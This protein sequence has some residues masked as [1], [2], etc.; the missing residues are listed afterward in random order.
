MKIQTLFVL[1]ATASLFAQVPAT[2]TTTPAPAEIQAAISAATAP[3]QIRCR[4]SFDAVKTTYPR[5][6][7]ADRMFSLVDARVRN[8]EAT[9]KENRTG[10]LY[11]AEQRSCDLSVELFKTQLYKVALQRS[12]DSLN[13][14]NIAAQKELSL[15]KDSLIDL[16]SREALGAKSLNT[17]GSDERARLEQANKEKA[18]ELESSQKA[19]AHK[20]AMLAAQKAEAQKRLD[21]LNS[22]AMSVYRDARGTI[23]SMSDI[24]FE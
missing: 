13:K 12:I 2:V 18:R 20:D 16:W 11:E 21:A 23:L 7:A 9:P 3:E 6:A 22:K 19:L 8:L 17:Y 24:L 1:A 4:S 14:N 10:K 15:V 5:D